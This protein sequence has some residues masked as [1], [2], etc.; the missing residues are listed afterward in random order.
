M[1]MGESG[2]IDEIIDAHRVTKLLELGCLPGESIT[3]ENIAPLGDP[4]AINL[5]GYKLS[6]RKSDADH[7]MVK[8]L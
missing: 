4:L 3:L 1:K 8:I 7:I 6:L 5:S 2:V